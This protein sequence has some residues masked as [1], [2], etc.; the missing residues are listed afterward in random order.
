MHERRGCYISV[1]G[2]R[3]SGLLNTAPALPANPTSVAAGPGCNVTSAGYYTEAILCN[4]GY[5]FLIAAATENSG[6]TS[7]YAGSDPNTPLGIVDQTS[8]FKVTDNG[9]LTS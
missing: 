3:T 7:I 5:E 8:G 6:F 9:S 2:G 4:N 1:I